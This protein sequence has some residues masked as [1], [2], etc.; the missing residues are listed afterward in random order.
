MS[1]TD[2]STHRS[3]R[4]APVAT[5][6]PPPQARVVVIGLVAALVL[7]GVV[8]SSSGQVPAILF[9]L[10]L[11]LGFVLFHSR[12][13]F[14][15][16]W[17]Q[18]V[19]VRQGKALRAHML[20]LAV[21]C[22]LFAPILANGIGFK[23]VPALP[24][25]AP[26]GFGLFV[27]SFMFGVGMQLGGSC[28]SGTLFAIGSG[29]TA[30]LLT[31]GGFIGGATLGAYQFPWWM[32]LPSHEPVSLT[33]WFGGYAGAW[34]ASLA[35]MALVVG[36]TYLLARNRSVPDVEPTPIAEGAARIVR[37]SW[38]LWVGALLLAALNAAT[39]WV[40]GGAWGVTFA[41]ALWGSKLLDLVGVDV[42]SWGF[43]QDPANLS[44]YDAGILAEK[45]SV[46]DFG[47]IIGALI[48]SAAAGAFVLHR[49]V[50]LR[51]AV[52]AVIGGLLMGYGARIAFG[53]NIGAYFGGIAS[54]SL[55]GWLW[56]VMA[57]VGT[58]VG[59]AFRPLLG[60]TNP[61]PSDS[62]C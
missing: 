36:A 30:I 20:M 12:F 60:L 46:M 43:W 58:Y 33:Q 11:G 13:G 61:K 28:A 52:G 18:L 24:T 37:G 3:T 34:A 38:P 54:F 19:A 29:H 35:L 7:G 16:A 25:L 26:I 53:C 55:H 1:T 6:E 5:T 2:R 44:K 10:G 50:P 47:I 45:T 39:L 59:L 40:S 4:V 49:R 32:D 9:A 62:V 57:I 17:R 23:D 48:A 8:Y 56:G 41:F 22:T 51:L 21:A 15:S 42:L 14:T 31:L 27:G